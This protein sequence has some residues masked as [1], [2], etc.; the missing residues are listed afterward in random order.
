[1]LSHQFVIFFTKFGYYCN[2]FLTK[3]RDPCET[4]CKTIVFYALK[5]FLHEIDFINVVV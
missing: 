3:L 2:Y 5:T 4:N 1:M